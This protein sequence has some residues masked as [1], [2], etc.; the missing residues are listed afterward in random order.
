MELQVKRGEWIILS[1]GRLSFHVTQS[2][3]TI[4]WTRSDADYYAP[5]LFVEF[6]K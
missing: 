2:G 5:A 4:G 1:I 6:W 3:F